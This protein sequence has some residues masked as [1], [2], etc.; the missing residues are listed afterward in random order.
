VTEKKCVPW[1]II[2]NRDDAEKGT[3][4]LKNLGTRETFENLTVEQASEK[5]LGK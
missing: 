5:I 3:M 1:G 2:I 4:T